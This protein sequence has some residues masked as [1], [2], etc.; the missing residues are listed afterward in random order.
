MLLLCFDTYNIIV[1]KQI[2]FLYNLKLGQKRAGVGSVGCRFSFFRSRKRTFSFFK[3]KGSN[4]KTYMR[5]KGD[6]HPTPP[7][8]P[9]KK[10]MP[11]LYLINY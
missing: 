9:I 4:D 5:K 8:P 1:K 7:T 10:G 6:L 11:S 2:N 3:K